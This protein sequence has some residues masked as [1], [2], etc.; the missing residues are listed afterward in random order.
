[1]MARHSVP[2][3]W[4][5]WLGILVLIATAV[6][7]A[8]TRPQSAPGAGPKV[9]VLALAPGEW[10]QLARGRRVFLE[11]VGPSLENLPAVA[12][13]VKASPSIVWDVIKEFVS[14]PMWIKGVSRTHT[15]R[16]AGPDIFV[17]FQIKH[18]L[19]GTINYSVKHTYPWPEVSWGTFVLD[20][21]RVSDLESASGLWRTFPVSGDPE[22]TDVLYAA[23]I[24]PKKGAARLFR[25]RIGK[26]GLKSATKWLTREA[27]SRAKPNLR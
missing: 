18:W 7:T 1:M 4:T 11:T 21:D 27:E 24:V 20:Q 2:P 23:Q 10:K 8:Y 5:M 6:P 16:E 3:P 17:E 9:L 22:A 14:Y 13:R 25:K 19:I 26:A 12:F 15:Y